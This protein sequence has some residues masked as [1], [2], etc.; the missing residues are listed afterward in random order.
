MS[1][2]DRSKHFVSQRH[3]SGECSAGFSKEGEGEGEK[4]RNSIDMWPP[5]D[6]DQATNLTSWGVNFSTS[7]KHQPARTLVFPH[8]GVT[9]G[10]R[11]NP[12][13]LS[14]LPSSKAQVLQQCL[15]SPVPKTPQFFILLPEYCC[16]ICGG[17]QGE[18]D[19]GIWYCSEPGGCRNPTEG[20]GRW[21]REEW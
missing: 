4:T 2:T 14:V 18:G 9:V 17:L 8:D 19:W 7:G 10:D 5:R 1:A 16:G 6:R 3:V 11:A 12:W 13:T 15:L 20:L 21:R